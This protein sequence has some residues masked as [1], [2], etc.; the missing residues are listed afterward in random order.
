MDNTSQETPLVPVPQAPEKVSFLKNRRLKLMGGIGL[1][2]V[3]GILVLIFQLTKTPTSSITNN[4][5]PSPSKSPELTT[6]QIPIVSFEEYKNEAVMPTTS[7]IS[8][9]TLKNNFTNAEVQ[10]FA[11]K[12]GLD[13]SVESAK[14]L[15]LYTYSNPASIGYMS[16]NKSSGAFSYQSYGN[17]KPTNYQ[18][19]QSPV[20]TAK[21]ILTDIGLYDETIYCPVTYRQT[22]L[23]EK[24][25]FV[26]CHRN[27]LKTGLPIV[28]LVG[29]INLPETKKIASL[30]VGQTDQSTPTDPSIINVSSGENGKVRPNQF[31]T[32][33]VGIKDDG[34]IF[35]ISSNL[36][37]I[38]EK[39]TVAKEDLV[40]PEAAI[41]ELAQ[42]K[43]Q[44]TLT[45]PAGSGLTDWQKVYPGGRANAKV[46]TIQEVTL[47]YPDKN[48]N[49][50][51]ASYDPTYLIRG[52]ATL[53]S[54]Y[55]VRFAQT[56]PALTKQVAGVSTKIAQ[57]SSL[58]LDTFD[59]ND[60]QPTVTAA[61]T[62]SSVPT[63]RPAPSMSQVPTASNLPTVPA[64]PSSAPTPAHQ[65][66]GQLQNKQP[67]E[68]NGEKVVFGTS[69]GGWSIYLISA[70]ENFDMTSAKQVF[71]NVLTEQYL[72][73]VA[74]WLRQNPGHPISS[75]EDVLRVFTAMNNG[76]VCSTS[77]FAPVFDCGDNIDGSSPGQYVYNKSIASVIGNRVAD[78][79]VA[80]GP[81]GI[82]ALAAKPN[83]FP[84]DVVPWRLLVE[85]GNLTQVDNCYISGVSPTIFLYPQ[86]M[87]AFNILLQSNTT[88]SDPK[89]MDNSWRGMVDVDGK[90]VVNNINRNSLYYEYDPKKVSF[91]IAPKGFLVKSEK[92]ASFVQDTLA[93]KLL[94]NQ[95]E[96]QT[97]LQE[98][99]SALIGAP[100]TPYL[101]ITFVNEAEINQKLPLTIEPTPKHLHRIHLLLTPLSRSTPIEEPAILPISREPFT[102]VEIGA[103]LSN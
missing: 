81:A 66:A 80:A 51:L 9:Y 54:G 28:N 23:P 6:N 87:T 57:S 71:Y 96:T 7:T 103:R 1:V 92:I 89:M 64:E 86:A 50:P 84:P 17:K 48:M 10:Q 78:S 72:I 39:K 33:T 18:A 5:L 29:V 41:A 37:M 43:S 61:P 60:S 100:N 56:I 63:T 53:E 19:G 90:L 97:L 4:N 11:K 74:R 67:F 101:K 13:L 36:R 12:L 76:S 91:N 82:A 88:Y 24:I 85:Y 49:T 93:A 98:V 102:I 75:R 2:L 15:N 40:K 46:A 65:C 95:A 34:T 62:S 35:S 52:I 21:Q 94:L 30:S 16:F 99:K 42:H 59:P 26:E 73:N 3:L 77:T 68:L 8:Y 32:V 25:T 44:F 69:S 47:V 27:W 83:I 45:I 14:T 79:I 38:S 22:G 31:N 70:P 55:T 20:T 58:Q